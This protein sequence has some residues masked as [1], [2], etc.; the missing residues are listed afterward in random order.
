MAGGPAELALPEC[1]ISE[2]IN[3]VSDA[4]THI[5]PVEK[6]YGRATNSRRELGRRAGGA[7]RSPQYHHDRNPGSLRGNALRLDRRHRRLRPDAHRRF[8]L[9]HGLVPY[10]HAALGLPVHRASEPMACVACRLLVVTG[11]LSQYPRCRSLR[12][13]D[14]VYQ[15]GVGHRRQSQAGIGSGSGGPAVALVPQAAG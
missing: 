13:E 5:L 4:D 15:I 3:L 11:M 8:A 12:G 7:A 2:L 6:R 1:V 14:L 10:R 9:L